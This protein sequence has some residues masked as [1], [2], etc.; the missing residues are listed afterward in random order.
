M[1]IKFFILFIV[2]IIL[3]CIL[4]VFEQFNSQVNKNNE[5]F[6]GGEPPPSDE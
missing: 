6:I 2:L 1:L 3:S 5:T 4:V